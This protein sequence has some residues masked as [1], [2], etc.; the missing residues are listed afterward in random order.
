MTL[1]CL[2]KEIFNQVLVQKLFFQ[3]KKKIL[4]LKRTEEICL[5]FLSYELILMLI[6]F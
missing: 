6:V 5:P 1:F 2:A 3:M 4:A